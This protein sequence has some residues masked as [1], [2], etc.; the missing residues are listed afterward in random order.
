L[1]ETYPFSQYRPSRAVLVPNFQVT[2]SDELRA[3][4]GLSQGQNLADEEG[5]QG[6]DMFAKEK[7]R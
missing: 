5:T 4:E 6:K 3:I 2:V 1:L 7:L